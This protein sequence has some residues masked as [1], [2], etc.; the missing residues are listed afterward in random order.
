MIWIP[1]VKDDNEFVSSY[2][3]ADEAEGGTCLEFK[4]I[5]LLS[6]HT[7]HYTQQR[8]SIAQHSRY[9]RVVLR[10]YQ[11]LPVSE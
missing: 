2:G 9:D 11:P 7:C 8:R 3:R 6:I 5:R 1:C 10:P 4:S